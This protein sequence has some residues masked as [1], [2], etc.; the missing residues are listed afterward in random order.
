MN[1]R[2]IGI[3]FTLA[4]ILICFAQPVIAKDRSV[5]V[6]R[7]GT[8]QLIPNATWTA[9]Q[10]NGTDSYDTHDSHNSTVQ[11]SRIYFNET[12]KYMGF[13]HV[14]YFANT[15]GLR[16]VAWRFNGTEYRFIKFIGTPTPTEFGI[17]ISGAGLVYSGSY[18]EIMV[19]QSSGAALNIFGLSSRTNTQIHLLD[20]AFE[21]EPGTT[22]TELTEGINQEISES[23]PDVIGILFLMIILFAIA[24]G[25]GIFMELIKR[26]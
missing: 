3:L 26:K 20:F 13:I 21:S 4:I 8:P 25:I 1:T 6:Q 17:D 11:N 12:G 2:R 22:G 5:A 14:T 15:T 24:A 7:D 19:Y 9:V 10:W 16:G 18:V 23:M